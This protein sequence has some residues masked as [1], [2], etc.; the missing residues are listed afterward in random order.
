[1]TDKE[2]KDGILTSAVITTIAI[3]FVSL[4]V[5]AHDRRVMTTESIERGWALY[6][7]N[8]GELAWIGECDK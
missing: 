5:V 1:M 7:P 6:C 8:D 2:T 4:M 3:L